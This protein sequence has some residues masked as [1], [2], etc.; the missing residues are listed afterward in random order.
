[1]AKVFLSGES[2]TLSNNNASVFG[3]TGTDKVIV[4]AGVT[5]LIIDQNVEGLQFAGSSSDYKYVQAGN[6]LKVYAS[7]GTTLLATAP[8]QGDADGTQMTFTDGTVDAKL[9]AGVMSF[10]GAT[11]SGT[12]IGAVTPTTINTAITSPDTTPRFSVAAGAATAVENANA[13]FVVTLSA[14]QVAPVTVN[15]AL[16]GTG[17]AVIGTDTG[18]ATVSGTGVTAAGTTLTFAAGSTAA[19]ITVP[20]TFD[21]ITETGEGISLA[22][23]S[24]STGMGLS[25]TNSTTA[26]V[27]LQD[28]ATAGFTLTSSAAGTPT[29][30]GNTIT[31]TVTPSSVV[32]ADTNLTINLTGSTVGAITTQAS[33][34]DFSPNS[35][36]VSFAAGDTAAKTA[37][38]TVVADGVSEGIEG[39]MPL[40]W[41][42]ALTKSHR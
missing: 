14:A 27:A 5:G 40:C 28:A 4:A 34:T 11:V 17:G 39:Y 12:T 16:T 23:S 37:I 42:V 15:Y 31:F 36:T 41:I 9:T 25:L 18:T 32:T 13:T 1:M 21:S 7:D 26:A 29:Q 38:V 2:F 19:T 35:T 10:G 20:I 3:G 24:P 6:Q 33:P 30:E 22:L 8:V